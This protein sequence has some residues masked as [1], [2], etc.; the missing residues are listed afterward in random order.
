MKINNINNWL[1]K[2]YFVVNFKGESFYY[3][4]ELEANNKYKQLTKKNK[5]E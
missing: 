5:Y 4:T 3:S 1:S 2:P